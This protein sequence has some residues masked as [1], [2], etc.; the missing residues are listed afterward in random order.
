M[1]LLILLIIFSIKTLN[2]IFLNNFF[3]IFFII[4]KYLS[5]LKGNIFS[6]SFTNFTIISFFFITS[7]NFN[8]GVKWNLAKIIQSHGRCSRCPT[9]VMWLVSPWA[10]PL[11][12]VLL[13]ALCPGPHRAPPTQID[14]WHRCSAAI[15]LLLLL[16]L[17]ILYDNCHVFNLTIVLVPSPWHTIRNTYKY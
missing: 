10:D 7:K 13:P 9:A 2:Y 6:S 5:R 11:I 16:Y 12:K 14:L 8:N 4:F 3:I 15:P 1:P 17:V